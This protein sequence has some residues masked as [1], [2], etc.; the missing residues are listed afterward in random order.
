[1]SLSDLVEAFSTLSPSAKDSF[2]QMIGAKKDDATR[3]LVTY[4]L[5]WYDTDR[6]FLK[7]KIMDRCPVEWWSRG[8][9][10]SGDEPA[11]KCSIIQVFPFVGREHLK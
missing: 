9:W 7:T 5:Y 6:T 10:K 2:L 1:M 8:L 4:E 3:Y 11:H